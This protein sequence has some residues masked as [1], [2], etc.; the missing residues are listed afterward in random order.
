MAVDEDLCM[1]H[2]AAVWTPVVIEEEA[3]CAED[4]HEEVERWTRMRW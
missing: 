2:R 4:V 1:R 3:Q